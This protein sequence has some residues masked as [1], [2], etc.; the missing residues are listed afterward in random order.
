MKK[1]YLKDAN[2][3]GG[4]NILTLRVINNP[5]NKMNLKI[6]GGAKEGKKPTGD[7]NSIDVGDG[8][9]AGLGSYGQYEIKDPTGK[10]I[11]GNERS[12]LMDTGTFPSFKELEKKLGDK[13]AAATPTPKDVKAF[14]KLSG[15]KATIDVNLKDSKADKEFHIYKIGE[16]GDG[17]VAQYIDNDKSLYGERGWMVFNDVED[18][19]Y[20]G[21]DVK[22][23]AKAFKEKATAS[24]SRKRQLA[25]FM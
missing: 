9:T 14:E 19:V 21:N 3:A 1:I 18:V 25:E 22:A 13:R 12:A 11:E 24:M 16:F 7:L 10:V 15:K 2:T 8:Y 17:G 4:E 6:Q 5:K 20:Q 23:A